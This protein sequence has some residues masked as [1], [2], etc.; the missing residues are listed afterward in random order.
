MDF[1]QFGLIPDSGK[2]MTGAFAKLFHYCKTN[3]VKSVSLPKGVYDFYEGE[4]FGVSLCPCG[5]SSREEPK[6]L[7]ALVLSEMDEFYL[8]GKGSTLKIHGNITAFLIN[9]SVKVILNN[10]NIIFNK[11]QSF[12]VIETG[13]NFAIFHSPLAFEGGKA[14]KSGGKVWNL[15]YGEVPMMTD[16]KA[17]LL[18]DPF[19]KVKLFCPFGKE[20]IRLKMKGK[21]KF[22]LGAAV[23]MGGDSACGIIIYNSQDISLANINI[24]SSPAT[25]CTPKR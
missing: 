16:G 10:F 17:Y 8:D 21:I 25:A 1:T 22:T 11:P 15:P 5:E 6:N 24:P 7:F 20:Y 19:K 13:K 9:S 18:N 3:A 23:P 4:A 14:L 2:D 12:S